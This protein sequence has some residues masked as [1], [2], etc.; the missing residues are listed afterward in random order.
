MKSIIITRISL[1]SFIKITVA[2][3][4]AIGWFLGILSLI[5]SLF[6]GPAAANIFGLKFQGIAGGLI[7]VIWVPIVF[8]VGLGIFSLAGFWPFLWLLRAIGGLK[9]D[10]EEKN[11]GE[12]GRSSESK[13][14]PLLMR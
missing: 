6:G 4:I 2:T 5:A 1:L 8:G 9:I 10:V 13:R 7:N 11:P 14:E 12:R 3:G